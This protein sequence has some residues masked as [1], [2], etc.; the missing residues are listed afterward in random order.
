MFQVSQLVECSRRDGVAEAGERRGGGGATAAWS[1]RA[2]PRIRLEV[3]ILVHFAQTQTTFTVVRRLLGCTA[4][5]VRAL[6]WQRRNVRSVTMVV[7]IYYISW[8]LPF[9]TVS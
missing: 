5:P 7:D 2:D 9:S 4:A 6:A 1:A 3:N 8:S